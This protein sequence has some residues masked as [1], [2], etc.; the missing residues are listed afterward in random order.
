MGPKI[1]LGLPD[2]LTPEAPLFRGMPTNPEPFLGLPDA[3]A[4][5]ACT[6]THQKKDLCHTCT[7]GGAY[8]KYQIDQSLCFVQRLFSRLSGIRVAWLISSSLSRPSPQVLTLMGVRFIDVAPEAS[9]FRGMPDACG[10]RPCARTH[11]KRLCAT[12]GRMTNTSLI[13]H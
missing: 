4:I 9:L 5:R 3:C 2:C 6:W 1:F 13:S 8:D 10:F 7:F 12:L 11:L